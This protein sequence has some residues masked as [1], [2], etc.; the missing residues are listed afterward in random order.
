MRRRRAKKLKFRN[1]DNKSPKVK[2]EGTLL[3]EA[4]LARGSVKYCFVL[5]IT[6]KKLKI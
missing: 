1:Y 2:K 5:L 6:K 3:V 4:Y